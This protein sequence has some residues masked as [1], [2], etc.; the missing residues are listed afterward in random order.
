MKKLIAI[1]LAMVLVLALGAV[2]VMAVEPPPGEHFT[3]NCVTEEDPLLGLGV[4]EILVPLNGSGMLT[5]VSGLTFEILDNDMTDGEA[6][7]QI[8]AGVYDTF[9]Q[10]RGKPGGSLTWG[11]YHVRA[12]GKPVWDQHNN[13]LS[14]PPQYGSWRF[15]NSGVT[16]YSFRLYLR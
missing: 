8:P 3:F 6:I 11:D 4:N 9:D 1:T 15:T 2:S 13:P 12:T 14:L 10:A 7:V 16:C 5:F